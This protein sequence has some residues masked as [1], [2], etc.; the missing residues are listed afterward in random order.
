[1]TFGRIVFV[2]YMNNAQRIERIEHI[3]HNEQQMIIEK[4]KKYNIETWTMTITFNECT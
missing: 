3:E 1:M 4:H 2:G